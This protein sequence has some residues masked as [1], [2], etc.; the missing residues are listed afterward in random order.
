LGKF[1]NNHGYNIFIV[2]DDSDDHVFLSSAIKEVMPNALITSFFDGME[3]LEYLFA[4]YQ[5]PDLIF[6][7]LNMRK[8][9][10]KPTLTIIKHNKPFCNIPIVV[11]TSESGIAEKKAVMQLGARAYY[12]KPNCP[13]QLVK[14]VE[15][16]KNEFL[17][18]Y[19]Y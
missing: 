5:V 3:V 1:L 10:G 4:G 13:H 17:V 18:H 9:D 19:Q 6:L 2:D 8:L 14:I 12:T 11:L 7:D 16:T 15:N